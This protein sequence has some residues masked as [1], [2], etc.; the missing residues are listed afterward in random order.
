M[1]EQGS[2]SLC[3]PRCC[4]I[5]RRKVQL[6]T[7]AG[8]EEVPGCSSNIILWY[9]VELGVKTLTLVVKQRWLT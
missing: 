4:F 8:S 2:Y 7:D 1:A 9:L 5:L 6:L 3:L